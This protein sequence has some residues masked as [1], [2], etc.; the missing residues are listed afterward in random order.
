MKPL[1]AIVANQY[2]Y[3]EEVFHHHPASYVPQFFLTAINAAGGVPVILPLVDRSAI[4]RYVSLYDG[5]LLTGGQGVSSFLYGEEPLPK[6]GTTFLQRDLFEIALVKA[7]A[8]THKPLLGVCRGLQVLN[9]ALG[10]TLYQDLA[11]REKPSLKHMQIPTADTQPTH[12]IVLAPDTVLAQTFGESAL[13]NSLHKQAIKQ[14]APGL[15]V[16]AHSSDQV[17]EALQISTTDHQFMGV[18]WHPEMLLEYDARQL[19]VFQDL[20]KKAKQANK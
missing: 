16:I 6:L 18:Q 1:I 14:V 3:A 5:F 8:Q 4:S 9:V 12:H 17:I 13:V 2:E 19:I 7:V 10:G 11:Y 20:V 15:E